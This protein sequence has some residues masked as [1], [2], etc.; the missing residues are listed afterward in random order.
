MTLISKIYYQVLKRASVKKGS[1]LIFW[2]KIN[3]CQ[4]K[5][6]GLYHY[7]TKCPHLKIVDYLI[8]D[9]ITLMSNI[10]FLPKSNFYQNAEVV[11]S[12]T[13]LYLGTKNG[14]KP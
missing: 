5:T 2:V 6:T 4:W 11:I 1:S 8:L 12:A 14:N 3:N 13:E 9:L 10:Y 7:L